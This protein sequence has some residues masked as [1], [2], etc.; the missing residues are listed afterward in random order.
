MS[1]AANNYLLYIEKYFG[2]IYKLV[3]SNNRK[4]RQVKYTKTAYVIYR[5]YLLSHSH[6]K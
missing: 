6:L 2:K 5:Y 4:F 3:I 1:L